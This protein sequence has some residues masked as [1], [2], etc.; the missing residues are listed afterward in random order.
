MNDNNWINLQSSAAG[1]Y[2]YLSEVRS[3]MNIQCEKY[4]TF[5]IGYWN[6]LNFVR[7]L[8]ILISLELFGGGVGPSVPLTILNN[9]LDNW[10][11]PRQN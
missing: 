8:S 11:E 2:Q 4:D 5:F 1:M 7:L 9:N 3:T 10:I 6:W